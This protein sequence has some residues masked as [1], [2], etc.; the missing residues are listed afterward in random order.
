MARV[1]AVV[2]NHDGGE[3]VLACLRALR[4][5]TRPPDELIV[6]DSGS[7]DGSP[8]RIRAQDPDAKL[9]ELGDNLG[10]SAARNAGLRAASSELVLLVDHDLYLDASGLERL[11]AAR[12]RDAVAALAPR[13][14]LHPE[15]DV[16]QADGAEA[17]FIGTLALRNGNRRL[18][19]ASAR[20]GPVGACASGCLLVERAAA[21]EAGGFDESYFFYFEDLEFSLRLRGRG[22]R[23]ACEPSAVARHD[24]GAGSPGLAFRGDGRYPERRAYLTMRNRWL[25]LLLH[26]RGRTLLLLVPALAL[27]ELA[28]LGVALARGWGR[29]WLRGWIWQARHAARTRH[30]RRAIQ[31]AR[32][33]GD[34]A[35]LGGGPLPLAPGFVRSRYGRR[36]AAAL[37]ALLDGYWRLVRCAVA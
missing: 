10:P 32:V 15:G 26:Y 25:T 18:R 24:R 33:V 16:V 7:R 34:R 20:A 3:R 6:V 8:G 37:S 17:H 35:L 11:L 14:V 31:D 12:E 27:Y 21:L 28:T 2:V 1:S 13:I 29:A 5:Q 19:E 30:R 9:V 4:A 36:A 22:G 23:M